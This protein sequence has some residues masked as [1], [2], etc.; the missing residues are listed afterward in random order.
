MRP[1][2]ISDRAHAVVA[3]ARRLVPVLLLA[4][5]GCL[6]SFHGGGLPRKAAAESVS[7]PV[8]ISGRRFLQ[9][10]ERQAIDFMK[11]SMFAWP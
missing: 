11:S 8:R 6:Y 10:A 1:S 7:D 9:G 4:L 5:G 2:G 3:V